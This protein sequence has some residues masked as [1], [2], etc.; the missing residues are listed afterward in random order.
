[1][2]IYGGLN[3]KI[4]QTLKFNRFLSFIIIINL[5]FYSVQNS[6]SPAVASHVLLA[7][8]WIT[9][10][11]FII[12]NEILLWVTNKP[13]LSSPQVF[14]NVTVFDIL[15]T[16]FLVIAV[17]I[18]TGNSDFV[19]LA[20]IPIVKAISCNKMKYS[21]NI[22][23]ICAAM[24]LIANILGWFEKEFLVSND[25]I[26]I[27]KTLSFLTVMGTLAYLGKIFTRVVEFTGNK[28]TAFHNMATTDV[29]TGLLNRREFNRRI[30]EEFAR[31]KRHK[32]QLS[33]ALFDIDFFKKINDTYG[34]NAG[35]TILRELGLFITNNTRTSDIAARYGG[36]EFALILPETSQLKAYELLDRLRQLVEEE[37]F[38]KLEKPVKATISVGVAQVDLSDKAP[39]DFCGRADKALYKAKE[40]GRNRVE[41]ASLGLPKIELVYKRKIA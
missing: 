35:D 15:C 24:I 31:A 41:R 7:L 4:S 19:F 10:G 39:I 9:L 23:L 18:F 34:H 17:T 36:E 5:I 29:L 20:L 26:I 25:N 6:G 1:M 27:S 28:A 16:S 38:N 12:F 21:I 37:T 8:S 13:Y 30:S 2:F 11:I 32:S 14:E 40:S 22:F 3:T 33:L